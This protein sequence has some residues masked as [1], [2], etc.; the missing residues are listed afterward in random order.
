M[1]KHEKK[2]ERELKTLRAAEAPPHRQD[3]IAATVIKNFMIRYCGGGNESGRDAEREAARLCGL[4]VFV[5]CRRNVSAC[6][7]IDLV[8]N[9]R[10][11]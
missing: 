7:Y 5:V 2:H 6:P 1:K 4:I 8:I 3:I 9:P 10:V 11:V